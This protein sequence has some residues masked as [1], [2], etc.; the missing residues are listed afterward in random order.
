MAQSNAL[1]HMVKDLKIVAVTSYV[2]IDTKNRAKEVGMS[3]V[4]S[5]PLTVEQM[6]E[7]LEGDVDSSD[8]SA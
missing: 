4:Y 5:K 2:N 3:K 1:K 8:E 6:K 7:I